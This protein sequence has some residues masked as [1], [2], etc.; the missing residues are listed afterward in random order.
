[1]KRTRSPSSSCRCAKST[2]TR[3]CIRCCGSSL[4]A[5]ST[6]ET[7]EPAVPA[8]HRPRESHERREGV[9]GVVLVLARSVGVHAVHPRHPLHCRACPACRGRT[10]STPCRHAER[11]GVE[12][13]LRGGRSRRRGVSRRRRARC[14]A[15][16][17]GRERV[18]AGGSPTRR[19]RRAGRMASAIRCRRMHVE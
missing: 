2:P 9:R 14:P 15:R 16:A 6:S 7:L 3:W 18:P 13:A 8:V 12:H 4:P 17:T 10:P 11:S 19:A 5:E 1:M